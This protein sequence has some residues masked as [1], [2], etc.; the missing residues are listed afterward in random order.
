MPPTTAAPTIPS[1]PFI[2]IYL[3]TCTSSSVI[4]LAISSTTTSWEQNHINFPLDYLQIP[5]FHVVVL[6]NACGQL[7]RS[8]H[9]AVDV[10]I[11]NSTSRGNNV[12]AELHNLQLGFNNGSVDD[13]NAVNS[14]IDSQQLPQ[15]VAGGTPVWHR[16]GFV[17][18][19][20][21]GVSGTGCF[22]KSKF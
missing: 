14:T 12:T 6:S 21:L 13:L 16:W 2:R 15:V 7:K 1:I 20:F 11:I 22:N 9:V 18:N 3:E 10:T 4:V 5:E 17:L 19:F 8:E